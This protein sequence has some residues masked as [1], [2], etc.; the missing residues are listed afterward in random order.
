MSRTNA[1]KSPK[2]EICPGQMRKK[3]PKLKYV[4]D[5]CP[6]IEICPGQM[7]NNL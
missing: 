4:Q 2:I 3:A 7:P 5:K 6:K 1:K